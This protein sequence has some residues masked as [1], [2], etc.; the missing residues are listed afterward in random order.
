MNLCQSSSFVFLKFSNKINS[1][2]YSITSRFPFSRANFSMLSHKFSSLKFSKQFSS[3]SSNTVV[4]YFISYNNSF[5]MIKLP[6]RAKPSSSIITSKS[7]ANFPV[8]SASI[9]YC[10]F[11]I[12]SDVSCH[13]LCTK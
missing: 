6:L 9:G 1:W 10:T 8:G 12:L 4:M 3:F 2:F 13:A 7:L 5:R 11:F